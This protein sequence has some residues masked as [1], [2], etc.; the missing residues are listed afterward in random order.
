MKKKS[1]FELLKH[2]TIKPYIFK[3]NE[4]IQPDDLENDEKNNYMGFFKIIQNELFYEINYKKK[5]HLIKITEELVYELQTG[6]RFI[7]YTANFLFYCVSSGPL[8]VKVG[9]EDGFIRSILYFS[10]SLL[11]ILINLILWIF[12]LFSGLHKTSK[13]IL[14]NIIEDFKNIPKNFIPDDEILTNGILDNIIIANKQLIIN[15]FFKKEYVQAILK[16]KKLLAMNNSNRWIYSILAYSYLFNG[17]DKKAYQIF[18]EMKRQPY[19]TNINEILIY[20]KKDLYIYEYFYTFFDIFLDDFKDILKVGEYNCNFTRIINILF[21]FNEE[22]NPLMVFHKDDDP[23]NE[24]LSY[25]KYYFRI[26]YNY[27]MSLSIKD[28]TLKEELLTIAFNIFKEL[29]NQIKVKTIKPSLTFEELNNL[30]ALKNEYKKLKFKIDKNKINSKKKIAVLEIYKK[31][32]DCSTNY[33]VLSDFFTIPYAKNIIVNV[34]NELI[35][36]EIINRNYSTALN[37]I[38]L[39]IDNFDLEIEMQPLLMLCLIY[40]NNITEATSIFEKNILNAGK[41]LFLKTTY[42]TINKLIIYGDNSNLIISFWKRL[43]YEY[44]KIID[45]I[46]ENENNKIIRIRLAEDMINLSQI[47]YNKTADKEIYDVL[48]KCYKKFVWSLIINEQYFEAEK[49]SLKILSTNSN[50]Q[51]FACNLIIIYALKNEMQNAQNLCA[52]IKGTKENISVSKIIKKKIKRLEAAKVYNRNLY[53][54]YKYLN[55]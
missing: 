46:Y 34:I 10:I 38:F 7:I 1:I 26:M 41:N 24:K 3:Y 50:S 32:F 33:D 55:N 43:F 19:L 2:S 23:P 40:C 29:H 18:K 52:N 49:E 27:Y 21:G 44:I 31:E 20:E 8:L 42:E 11:D 51:D 35:I 5:R 30:K 9:E 12:L 16:S 47:I 45:Q 39:I 48:M 22:A 6:G 4:I 14:N 54:V 13:H 53:K 37:H 28:M 25:R 17:Q 36:T 15:H